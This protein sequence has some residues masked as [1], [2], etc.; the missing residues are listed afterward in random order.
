MRLPLL[1][2]LLAAALITAPEA[3]TQR[4]YAV[5]AEFKRLNPCPANGNRR[6]PCEGFQVDHVIPLCAGGLD[7]VS[8]LQWLT[9]E[10]HKAKTKR[11]SGMCRRSNREYRLRID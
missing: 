5:K 3:K 11:E 4:S 2:A 10:E 1:A 8:N 7:D 6:G 9:V